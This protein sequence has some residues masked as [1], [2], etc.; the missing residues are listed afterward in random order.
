MEENAQ[1]KTD[2]EIRASDK[3]DWEFTSEAKFHVT[4]RGDAYVIRSPINCQHFTW[5]INKTV[6]IDGKTFKVLGVEPFGFKHIKRGMTIGLLVHSMAY[7]IP[8]ETT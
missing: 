7:N 3:N 4:G 1:D 2:E 6:K 5:I 8:G